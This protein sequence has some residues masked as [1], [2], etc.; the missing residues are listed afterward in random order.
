MLVQPHAPILLDHDSI[1]I[2]IKYVNYTL[3]Q[4]LF[5]FLIYAE[6][7]TTLIHTPT[8]PLLTSMGTTKFLWIIQ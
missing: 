1:P 4:D 6:Y 5:H 8:V 2:M 7:K 3:T